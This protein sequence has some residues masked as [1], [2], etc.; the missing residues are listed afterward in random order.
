MYTVCHVK[1]VVVWLTG[2]WSLGSM[3]KDF[4]EEAIEDSTDKYYVQFKG[5]EGS[6]LDFHCF[7]FFPCWI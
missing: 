2:K 7:S 1:L 3:M 4:K 5:P 6:K